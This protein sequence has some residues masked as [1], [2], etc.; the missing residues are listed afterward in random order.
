MMRKENNVSK[1]V[2]DI[3]SLL[4]NNPEKKA[5]YDHILQKFS[6][7]QVNSTVLERYLFSLFQGNTKMIGRITEVLKEPI[8][9]ENAAMSYFQLIQ[10][11]Q[12]FFI[13]NNGQIPNDKI[14]IFQYM[15]MVVHLIIQ[16]FL[17][18]SFIKTKFQSTH[19]LL[20]QSFIR[21]VNEY[22]HQ[23]SQ[24]PH[25]TR[26][27][28]ND[29][30]LSVSNSSIQNK[31]FIKSS[32]RP[33]SPMQLMVMA[34][35]Q[36][37]SPIHLQS[38]IRC[39]MLFGF[40]F[41]DDEY[42][43]NWIN[44]ID[45]MLSNFFNSSQ[46]ANTPYLFHPSQIYSQIIESNM[47]EDQIQWIFGSAILD[48]LSKSV[49]INGENLLESA[50]KA[51][52]N[53]LKKRTII[54]IEPSIPEMK[55]VTFLHSMK[56]IINF[57]RC[58]SSL[59]GIE[60]SLKAIYGDFAPTLAQI[61]NNFE[62]LLKF[63]ERLR[64][65][66]DIAQKKYTEIAKQKVLQLDIDSTAWR[67]AYWP[68]TRKSYFLRTI[69]LC[70]YKHNL[71]TKKIELSVFY[72]LNPFVKRFEKIANSFKIFTKML[73]SR[74]TFFSFEGPPLALVYFFEISKMISD[75]SQMSKKELE[76]L[77]SLVFSSEPPIQKYVGKA[78]AHIDILALNFVQCLHKIEKDEVKLVNEMTELVGFM[79]DEYF[80][81]IEIS[82]D[83]VS[84]SALPNNIFS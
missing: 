8:L 50:S 43:C 64:K 65:S 22:M 23:I 71:L 77:A 79:K 53:A 14:E 82:E 76:E 15:M 36:I 75:N 9:E 62:F 39:L 63:Y 81:Q 68:L 48:L 12:K 67:F 10:Y 35:L 73:H 11:I 28:I 74:G 26:I 69:I 40:G 59:Q 17:P 42:A 20:P 47:T 27:M 46:E 57:I 33:N 5:Q 55:S 25:S 2:N 38:L 32:I 1:L 4:K 60:E 21:K 19:N 61:G 72:F 29:M 49:T 56:I 83:D 13:S 44:S 52:Q 70:G 41:I 7:N 31:Y 3:Q 54:E 16:E 37:T 45:P 78:I 66:G 34:H 84:I 30:Y 6:T 18:Y 24:A 51:D 58:G 80:Y